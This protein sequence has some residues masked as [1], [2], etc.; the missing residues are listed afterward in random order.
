MY[1]K[2]AAPC[3]GRTDKER[4]LGCLELRMARI[5]QSGC[6][7]CGSGEI[8]WLDSI[9]YCVTSLIVA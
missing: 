9:I 1:I 4:F 5:G 3:D 6:G 2:L 8:T 7:V